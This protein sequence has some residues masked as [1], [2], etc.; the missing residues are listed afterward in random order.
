MIYD[1]ALG[2]TRAERAFGESVDS[3][4]LRKDKGRRAQEFLGTRKIEP[5]MY[6]G[7]RAS[8]GRYQV[9]EQATDILNKQIRSYNR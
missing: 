8:Y 9:S 6:G 3:K 2:K 4:G 1:P 5:G 7:P